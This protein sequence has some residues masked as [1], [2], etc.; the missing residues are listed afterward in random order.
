MKHFLILLSLTSLL[1]IDAQEL[2]HSF[3]WRNELNVNPALADGDY[4]TRRKKFA[5]SLRCNSTGDAI[6]WS[7]IQQLTP[8]DAISNLNLAARKKVRVGGFRF[9]VGGQANVY[10]TTHFTFRSA[11]FSAAH[12]MRITRP[13]TVSIGGELRANVISLRNEFASIY[14]NQ[15]SQEGITGFS[16]ITPGAGVHLKYDYQV[17]VFDKTEMGFTYRKTKQPGFMQPDPS[18][19][20]TAYLETFVKLNNSQYKPAGFSLKGYYRKRTNA[21]SAPEDFNGNPF[22]AFQSITAVI[23]I[24]EYKNLNGGLS[25]QDYFSNLKTVGA[26]ANYKIN[27]FQIMAGAT[28]TP[29]HKTGSANLG[30]RYTHQ[31]CRRAFKPVVI[32]CF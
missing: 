3:N 15:P 32:G 11:S 1:Q 22:D 9:G 5:S 30:V 8:T 29:L 24:R 27:A 31:R 12:S 10:N 13:L 16:G 17:L 26:Y 23:G 19:E 4:L 18:H 7:S 28:Y 25:Y 21:Y 20:I 6:L 14:E 2:D